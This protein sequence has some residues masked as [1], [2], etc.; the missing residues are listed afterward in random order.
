MRFLLALMLI[1]V[2]FFATNAEQMNIQQEMM[3]DRKPISNLVKCDVCHYVVKVAEDLLLKNHTT[4]Q[5]VSHLETACTRLPHKWAKP[6]AKIVH[7]QAA[8]IVRK[9]VQHEKPELVCKQLHFCKSAHLQEQ[10]DYDYDYEMVEE[11]DVDEYDYEFSEVDDETDYDQVEISNLGRK[12]FKP[13]KLNPLKPLKKLECKVCK[14]IVHKAEKAVTSGRTEREIE[15]LLDGECNHFGI[16]PAVK[17]CKKIVHSTLGK[18]IHEIKKNADAH[19]VCKA[20]H[21]CK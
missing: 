17:M 12:K 20:V 6:C 2:A 1:F 4:T 15:H 16:H 18:I 19:R 5:I 3:L 9:L 11:S 13:G 8:S 7:N 14:S 21:M 10:E